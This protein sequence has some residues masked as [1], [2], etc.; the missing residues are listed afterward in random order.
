[1]MGS[2]TGNIYVIR[3]SF[4]ALFSV[5]LRGSSKCLLPKS[6]VLAAVTRAAA[7]METCGR[8][9]TPA[10]RKELIIKC[11]RKRFLFAMNDIL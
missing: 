7:V 1:M 2:F 11:E 4:P 6:D 3:W 9:V 8:R 5:T 10:G